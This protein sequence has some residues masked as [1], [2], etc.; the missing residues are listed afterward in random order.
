MELRL[1]KKYATAEE[2]LYMVSQWRLIVRKFRKHKLANVGLAVLIILYTIAAFCEFF[3]V[4]DIT[5]RDTKYICTSA[6][7]S[8]C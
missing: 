7:N 1:G 8:L 5:K 3:A 4:Q 6:E 2:K